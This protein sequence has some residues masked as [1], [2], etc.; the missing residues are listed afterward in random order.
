MQRELYRFSSPTMQTTTVRQF[1]TESDR[2]AM[3]HEVLQG[4]QRVVTFPGSSQYGRTGGGTSACGL[5]ALNC[6]RII[7]GKYKEGLQGTP[8]LETVMRRETLQ[9]ILGICQSWSNSSHLEVD[10]ISAAPIFAMT[11]RLKAQEYSAS[12]LRNLSGLLQ[13][14]KPAANEP[15][16]AVVITRPPE[17]IVC[18]IIRVEEQDVFITF[19]SHPRPKHP[20]GAAFIFDTSLPRTAE[21]LIQLLGYDPKLLRDRTMQWEAQMLAQFSGHVFVA[22]DIP[23]IPADWMNS[24]MEASLSSLALKAEVASLQSRNDSLTSDNVRLDRDVQRLQTELQT[25]RREQE[26]FRRFSDQRRTQSSR[27]NELSKGK[28]PETQRSINIRGFFPYF[29]ALVGSSDD[30][31]E[32]LQ[33]ASAEHVEEVPDDAGTVSPKEDEDEDL[34]YVIQMQLEYDME[35]MRLRGQMEKLKETAQRTFDCMICLET[36]PED[37][38]A[39]LNSCKH[40]ICTGC[41]RTY[42]HSKLQEGRFPIFCPVCM[43]QKDP[44]GEVISNV[45]A[46]QIGLSEEDFQT[47]IEFELTAFSILMHCRK[48]KQSVFVDRTEYNET[49]IVTCPLPGCQYTWCKQCSQEAAAVDGVK[50]SC[51]GSAELQSLMQQR[52]WKNCP[53]CDTPTE[54]TGGC[55]HMTCPAP[56]CNSHF[57][58]RCGKMIIQSVKH[59]DVSSA[60]AT[61]YSACVLFQYD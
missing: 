2:Q 26:R 51:D 13:R 48:C 53:G 50:H 1:C 22:R 27:G 23:D 10:E 39:P 35:D 59:G 17:I 32:D 3:A 57:C 37:Y 7:L 14:A 44:E 38:I 6:A 45:L 60:M 15:P 16:A 24:L 31:K 9:N 46:Q 52:G 20:D 40:F 56:G 18:M 47:F 58:Y 36:I 12:S 42:V 29:N 8:L 21:Y 28:A 34:D 61:H 43:T 4:M 55:N 49:E 5:A 54:K 19:D 11:L 30:R 25:L 33:K 41:L